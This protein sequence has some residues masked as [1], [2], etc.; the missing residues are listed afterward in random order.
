MKATRARALL[1]RQFA[2]DA[3]HEK[4][5]RR[6]ADSHMRSGR[7]LNN[8]LRVLETAGNMTTKG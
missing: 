8:H 3:P 1:T 4:V 5:Q 2:D 7:L 6:T